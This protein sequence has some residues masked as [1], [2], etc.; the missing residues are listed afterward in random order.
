MQQLKLSWPPS[1]N[2]LWRAYK[3]RNILSRRARL[4]AEEA[5]KELL[6]QNAKPVK[7]PVY[8]EIA[9]QSPF[10]RP[11]DPDNRIKALLDLLV[12]NAIL[13]QDSNSIIHRL[14][15]HTQI[16]GFEGVMVT[17]QEVKP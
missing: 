12:K 11:Y 17:I 5:S 16:T 15:V 10:K 3:G 7:G 6:A 8:I 9:L 1:T 2:D 14:T 4:W 13:E